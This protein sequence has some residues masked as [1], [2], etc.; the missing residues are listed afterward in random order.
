MATHLDALEQSSLHFYAALEKL[1]A[2]P[3]FLPRGKI[4]VAIVRLG[5]ENN[6]T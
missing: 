5:D 3:L 6:N 4:P 2:C 1:F